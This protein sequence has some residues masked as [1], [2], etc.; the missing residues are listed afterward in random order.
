MQHIIDNFSSVNH[1]NVSGS[2]WLG[3]LGS[4]LFLLL[5]LRSLFFSIF[6]WSLFLY[7]LFA[8]RGEFSKLFCTRCWKTT[9]CDLPILLLIFLDH[10][11][12][13]GS[14]IL[15]STVIHA[16][17]FPLDKV[18]DAVFDSLTIDQLLDHILGLL[19]LSHFEIINQRLGNLFVGL[20]KN[21]F[22]YLC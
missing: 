18:W 16:V 2:L 11:G 10:V 19:I 12:W 13:K 7:L 8:F 3:R 4:W 22:Y 6:C 15:P 20:Y 17:V 1:G 14:S 9:A 5:F 21:R